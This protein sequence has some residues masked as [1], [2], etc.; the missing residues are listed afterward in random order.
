MKKVLNKCIEYFVTIA[1]ILIYKYIDNKVQ[2][3][4]EEK[5]YKKVIKVNWLGFK[6]I[7]YHEI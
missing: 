2:K 1:V 5:K 3:H 7:E 6:S 4:Q